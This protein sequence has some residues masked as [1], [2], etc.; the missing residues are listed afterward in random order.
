MLFIFGY[1][2]KEFDMRIAIQ[3]HPTRGK[4]V[5]QILK[6][7]GGKNTDGLEGTYKTFYYIDDKNEISDDHK[8]NFP[9]TY[10]LYTLEEFEKEFPFK[11]G[12]EVTIAG[13]PDFPKIITQMAWDCDEILYSFEDSNN[14]WF[15]AKALKKFKMKEERNITLTLDKAK[16]WY[17][18]GG[19]LREIAL[20]AYSK[21]EL[22][23]LPRSWEEFATNYARMGYYI[24]SDGKPLMCASSGKL[25]SPHVCPSK[26]SAEAHLAMIQLEQLRDCYR[27]L[28]VT[29][30]G[31]PVW[32]ISMYDGKPRIFQAMWGRNQS[33]LSFQ[34]R[35]VAEE[36]LENFKP[37]IEKAGDLI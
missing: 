23:P 8:K 20:Q 2:V 7:L 22:N 16:E 12:D 21:E 35:K 31:M 19:E 29:V 28:F 24:S 18:K 9:P 14:T 27:G 34:S 37:L 1:G 15:S 26:E 5:I 17:K 32:N 25:S 4:E 33:F 13:L 11:I 3:G 30:I 10:K 36:Y 6:S